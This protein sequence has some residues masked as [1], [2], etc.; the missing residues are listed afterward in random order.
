MFRFTRAT[1]FLAL[2]VLAAACGRSGSE[3]DVSPEVQAFLDRLGDDVPVSQAAALEDGVITF[4][5]YEAAYERTV[6]C[7]RDSGLVV[8][9]PIPVNG[10]RFLGYAYE[11]GVDDGE[12]D[13]PC[14]REHLD[15]VE[16]LWGAQAMPSVAEAEVIAQ[17]YTACLR[18]AGVV[19]EGELS[20]EEVD[21]VALEA[22]PGPN[23]DAVGRCSEQYSFGIFISDG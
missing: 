21:L 14:L 3:A 8:N 12:A 13:E 23:G 7:M 1:L 4:E 10:G 18:A 2:V 15:L 9:G 11:G 17:E 20:L 19:I 22:A 16:G 6:A 5:E